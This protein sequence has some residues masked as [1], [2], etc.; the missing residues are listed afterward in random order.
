MAVGTTQETGKTAIRN[1]VPSLSRHK[2]VEAVQI[3][4]EHAPFITD[5]RR[6]Q[7]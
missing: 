6:E 3:V 7:T 1:R 5:S 4:S 2:R